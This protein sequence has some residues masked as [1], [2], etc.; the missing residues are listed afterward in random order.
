[1]YRERRV[2]GIVRK[3]ETCIALGYQSVHQV[4]FPSAATAGRNWSAT[5][6]QPRANHEPERKY[7]KL[8]FPSRY[9][10]WMNRWIDRVLMVSGLELMSQS[11][12]SAA[13]L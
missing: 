8:E 5:I 9:M 13:A 11:S 10:T 3:Y 7:L 1:M 2:G 6:C 4:T 12:C